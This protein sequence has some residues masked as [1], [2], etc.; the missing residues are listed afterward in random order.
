[1]SKHDVLY[2]WIN[3]ITFYPVG[4]YI[5]WVYWTLGVEVSFYVVI[6]IVLAFK[7]MA[8]LP[9][10]IGLIGTVSLT[11]WLAY[12]A[13][14]MWP[15]A[16]PELSS[17]MHPKDDLIERLQALFLLRHGCFFAIGVFLWLCFFDGVNVK[18]VSM[19]L[20]FVCGGLIQIV[21]TANDQNNISHF[22]FSP[23]TPCIIWILS[24]GFVVAS[25][26]F[27]KQ[28]TIKF[29]W[30]ALPMRHVGLMTYPLYLIHQ[31]IGFIVIA[32]THHFIGDIW[33]LCLALGFVTVL[34][35]SISTYFEPLMRRPLR[36]MITKQSYSLT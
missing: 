11:F 4:Q 29:K 13:V 19:I 30:L 7:K 9:W 31:K 20:A 6:L 36:Y 10:I 34:A 26:L 27:N 35:Y 12:V 16:M 8:Y 32:A 21:A 18:R 17:V 25:V 14:D 23:V 1:M 2:D 22:G 3:T 33:S 15:G 24:I 5:D 28:M